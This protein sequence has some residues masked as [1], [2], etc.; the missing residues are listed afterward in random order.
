[1][2]STVRRS[3]A[4]ARQ[5]GRLVRSRKPS[6][7]SRRRSAQ[8]KVM[9]VHPCW[10]VQPEGLSPGP[11]TQGE[12]WCPA[13]RRI[14]PPQHSRWSRQRC[15][16]PRHVH[17]HPY[18]RLRPEDSGQILQLK[19][20]RTLHLKS[21]RVPCRIKPANEREGELTCADN[22]ESTGATMAWPTSNNASLSV[23]C[24]SPLDAESA[25]QAHIARQAGVLT[26]ILT[27]H[28]AFAVTSRA[29]SV[30]VTLA[31]PSLS[32]VRGDNLRWPARRQAHWG[33]QSLREA[34]TER[35]HWPHRPSLRSST[36]PEAGEPERRWV[37]TE[38]SGG[39]AAQLLTDRPVRPRWLS[40]MEP[41][42]PGAPLGK[43]ECVRIRGRRSAAGKSCSPGET[44][45]RSGCQRGHLCCQ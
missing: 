40:S 25:P 12:A 22:R 38:R 16:R 28:R 26:L 8:T 43:G 27:P 32:G 7:W 30:L 23:L 6:R 29:P 44:A 18:C 21:L 1:M 5:R 19:V 37:K 11:P 41:G 45:A 4:S 3:T 36:P 14:R 20:D 34:R 35:R 9:H 13:R 42:Q 39:A 15:A 24:S 2:V 17:F 33:Q 31:T 10:R